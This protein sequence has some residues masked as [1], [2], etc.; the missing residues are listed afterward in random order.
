MSYLT[1]EDVQDF[2]MDRGVEDNDLEL[3]LAFAPEEIQKAMNRAA[4]EYNSIPPLGIS[5]AHG[6][7]LP[8]DTNI[9]LY[10]TSE[11]LCRSLL[12]KLRRNDVDYTAGGVG[13]NLVAK[14]IQHLREQ[15]QEE[16]AL[17]EPRA[18]EFKIRMNLDQ[19]FRT[20]D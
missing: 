7:R 18:R 15:V 4:R 10:A 1:V 14:R 13:V 3:D 2:M 20:F 19:A 8:D 16:R 12:H 11:Q 6:N 9:F 17:W 5:S